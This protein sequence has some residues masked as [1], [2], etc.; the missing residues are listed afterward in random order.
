VRGDGLAGHLL[1]KGGVDPGETNEQA[2]RREIEEEAGLTDLRLRDTL[3]SR[4]RLNFD[5]NRWQTTHYFLFLTAQID[6]TPTDPRHAYD[7]EWFPLD[8]LPPMFWPEQRALLEENSGR[9]EE[10]VRNFGRVNGR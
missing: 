4:E 3:G 5:R 7:V 8:A 1:P 6:G 9:I 2:A 10:S